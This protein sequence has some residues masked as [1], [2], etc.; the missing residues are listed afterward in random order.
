MDRV[1]ARRT[2]Q[3]A[4]VRV[5][6]LAAAISILVVACAL[7]EPPPPPGTRPIQAQVK[8]NATVPVELSVQTPSGM[9][10]GAVQP[11]S[12]AP[13]E[14]GDVTFHLPMGG[15]WWISVNGMQMF[16]STDV[17]EYVRQ[18]CRLGMEVSTDGS[19]G[20]GCYTPR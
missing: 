14:I 5:S 6:A 17:D 11:V 12:L 8:N 18:G 20:I 1:L 9:L 3:R 10:A 15:E 2:M 4:M 16:S 7:V 19:G 13:K